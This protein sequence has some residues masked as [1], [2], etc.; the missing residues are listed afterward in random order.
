M[1]ETLSAHFGEFH[2][3]LNDLICHRALGQ[4]RAINLSQTG[5]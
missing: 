4:G 2:H 1:L 5:S 3:P